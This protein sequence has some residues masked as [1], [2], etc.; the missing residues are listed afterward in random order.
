MSVDVSAAIC[1]VVPAAVSLLLCLMQSLLLIYVISQCVRF[2]FH[3]V[4]LSQ[5]A[6]FICNFRSL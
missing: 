5:I 6:S 1:V 2:N 4:K 3:G